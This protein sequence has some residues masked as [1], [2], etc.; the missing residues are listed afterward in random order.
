[1]EIIWLGIATAFDFMILKW[2]FEHER[3]ADFTLDVTCLAIITW[4]FHGTIT[5]MTIG[6]VAMFIISFYLLLFPPKFL[7]DET[8]PDPKG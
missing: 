2:K 3:Y 4:L 1:M 8:E 5:G 7:R 6:M